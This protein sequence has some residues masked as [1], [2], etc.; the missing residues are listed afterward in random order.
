MKKLR[1]LIIEDNENDAQLLLRHLLGTYDLEY[2]LVDTADAARAALTGN[3]WEIVLSDYRMPSFSALEALEIVKELNL[4]IPFIIISGTIG[5]EMA[6]NTMLAGAD[7]FF[8]KGN[9]RRLVPAIERELRESK[10][11][12]E[13]REAEIRLN[14]AISSAGLGVWEWNLT[15]DRVIWSPE[16]YK[17]FGIEKFGGRIEDFLE[18]VVPEDRERVIGTARQATE[19]GQ[20]FSL[21]FRIRNAGNDLRWLSNLGTVE[22]GA[23]DKPHRIIGTLQDITERKA[24]ETLVRES[25]ENFRALIE[26]STL[27]TWTLDDKGAGPEVYDWLSELSGRKVTTFNDVANLIH[28]DDLENLRCEWQNAVDSRT[29]FSTVCRFRSKEGGFRYL[30]IRGAQVFNEDG[31]FRKWIGTFNDITER[32]TAEDELKKSEALNRAV[33]NSMTSNIAVLDPQG[34]VKTLNRAWED[35]VSSNPTLASDSQFRVE[36][37]ANYPEFC[38]Q[39]SGDFDDKASQIATAIREVLTGTRRRYFFE[40]CCKLPGDTRW[41][42]ML[43]TPLK[44]REGGAVISHSDITN[45][46]ITEEALKKNEAQLQLVADTVPTVIAYLDTERRFVFSNEAFQ[47]WFRLPEGKLIGRHIREVLGKE[48]YERMSPEIDAVLRGEVLKLER[49]GLLDPSRYVHINYMP[50]CDAKGNI[51]GFFMF[52]VDLTDSRRAEEQ[53]RKSEEQ[54]RQAQ[55]LESIG[56]LA[57]GIAHDFNNMLTAINGYCELTL[58]RLPEGAPLRKN[59]EEI[60]KAGERSVALTNQLLAFSRQQILEV[61]T[62][63]V[64]RIVEDSIVMLQRV[65][66]ED[67]HINL[68]LESELWNIQGDQSQLTQVLLNLVV[69]SRDAMPHGGTITIKTDNAVLDHKFVLRR[70]GAREG[71]FVCLSVADTGI[72]MDEETQRH[73]FEPFFTTKET[74][75]GT[76]LGL[77]M[78]YGI[79]KQLNGYVWVTSFPDGGTTFDIYLP[80][81]KAKAEAE[82][83]ASNE[84]VH[85]AGSETILLVEDED[86]VRALSR[87][88]LESCGYNIVEAASGAAA[89]EMIQKGEVNIDLLMT[90][91]VM[92][93]M[94]GRELAERLA[95]IRPGLKVLFTSGYLEEPVPVRNGGGENGNFIQ[96]PFSYDQLVQKVRAILDKD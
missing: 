6:V 93:V 38:E 54:L 60:K 74:G 52:L 29:V 62:L 46:K 28:P 19:N 13:K 34:S 47:K 42:Y 22:Y 68:E 2:E 30:A 18:F 63:D 24:A 5:E 49:T 37:G 11:R 39:S 90:D 58:L 61:S 8:I 77:S 75:K 70:P 9:L 27:F 84:Q 17:M 67:I 40:Y 91:V 3:S 89:I 21:E 51:H 4:G 45:R 64:N 88:V 35:F 56:R 31:S 72:G 12:R 44:T 55:K 23:E 87:Q 95:R 76:G 7:D 43:V 81:T 96:K 1:A 65:I 50:D 26:A 15:N 25:E 16:I 36:I 59:I 32:K 53:L 14:L 41:F 94:G 79:I 48:I 20:R 86:L 57:G 10:N 69:N 83:P 66:G 82:E 78:V 71:K 73:I 33:L 80:K 92:P 85:A